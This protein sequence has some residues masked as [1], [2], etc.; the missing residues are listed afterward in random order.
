[1]IVSVS[2]TV[3]YCVHISARLF[4]LLSVRGKMSVLFSLKCA[5]QTAC[6]FHVEHL[7]IYLPELHPWSSPSEQFQFV[8]VEDCF[9]VWWDAANE[10]HLK[11][12]S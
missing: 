7:T 1:M 11:F 12:Q 3:S 6:V 9:L 8:S 5:F 10:H 2:E 4:R